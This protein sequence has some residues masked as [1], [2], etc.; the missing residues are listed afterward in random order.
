MIAYA[1]GGMNHRR[2]VLSGPHLGDEP[3]RLRS[4]REQPDQFGALLGSEARRRAR[5]RMPVQRV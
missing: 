4:L 3:V 2:D 1:E 5:R